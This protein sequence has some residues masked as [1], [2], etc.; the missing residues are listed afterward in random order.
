MRRGRLQHLGTI[1]ELRGANTDARMEII[2]AGGDTRALI[3]SFDGDAD[4]SI[5]ATPNGA[6]IVV[7]NENAVDDVIARA[8]ARKSQLVSVN[9]LGGSLE[10]LFEEEAQP[11]MH[12]EK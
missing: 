8:R 2:I 3:E 5:E 9:R 6:R 12:D 1:E 10:Q 4:A 7:E 11:E